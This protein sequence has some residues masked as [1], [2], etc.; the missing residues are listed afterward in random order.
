MTAALTKYFSADRNFETQVEIN[1][2]VEAREAK[3]VSGEMGVTQELLQEG[4][5]I[6]IVYVKW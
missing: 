4:L 6:E 2:T 3:P 5:P 1:K